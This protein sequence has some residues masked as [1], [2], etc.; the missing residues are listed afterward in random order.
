MFLKLFSGD[1]RL[2]KNN[3]RGEFHFH[4]MAKIVFVMEIDNSN[5]TMSAKRET[6]FTWRRK[7]IET[8]GGKQ[9]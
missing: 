6:S 1:L 3:E 8:T 4:R 2:L 7:A 5:K 9:I